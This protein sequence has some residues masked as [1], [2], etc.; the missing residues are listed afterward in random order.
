MRRYMIII[1][2]LVAVFAIGL[3]VYLLVAPPRPPSIADA[4]AAVH[5]ATMSL[6]SH[7]I[8]SHMQS[9]G[10]DVPTLDH[11]IELYPEITT[12]F[13]LDALELCKT[14]EIVPLPECVFIDGTA[15]RSYAV[16]A[17]RPP[18]IGDWNTVFVG[19]KQVSLE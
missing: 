1:I 11:L 19:G 16:V 10:T 18:E 7:Y 17:R 6:I 5:R 14:F 4:D 15:H 12:D 13:D 2:V 3:P 8:E 9:G